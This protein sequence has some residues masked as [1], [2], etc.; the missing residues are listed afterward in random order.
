MK[1]FS[2]FFLYL[3][4]ATGNDLFADATVQNKPVLESKVY[5]SG[6]MYL[7]IPKTGCMTILTS[8]LNEENSAKIGGV[9]HLHHKPL[10]F[11]KEQINRQN[12]PLFVFLRDPLQH[13]LSILRF[14][15]Y[16]AALRLVPG[17]YPGNQIVTEAG[18]NFNRKIS[19][20]NLN[21]LDVLRD[22]AKTMTGQYDNISSEYYWPLL[23]YTEYFAPPGL[24]F[25]KM[26]DEK[27][28]LIVN[29]ALDNIQFF[30]QIEEFEDSIRKLNLA[31]NLNFDPLLAN[32]KENETPAEIE[33][34]DLANP[35]IKKFFDDLLV[36]E[37]KVYRGILEG[38]RWRY[39][40]LQPTGTTSQIQMYIF[41]KGFNPDTYIDQDPDLKEYVDKTYGN[42][43]WKKREYAL[44][45]YINKS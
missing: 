31:F 41:P 10:R 34:I 1:F 26:N 15:K 27:V 19:K 29:Y 20:A 25:T 28:N 2:A 39:S 33:K 18:A 35:E 45:N 5:D 17:K 23:S 9:V 6:I 32:K 36:W 22:L 40:K 16:Y 30:G 21:D 4:L 3:I 38:M 13:V 12:K 43:I 44:V 37:Y 24:D 7:S 42:D 14:T 11:V 8:Y